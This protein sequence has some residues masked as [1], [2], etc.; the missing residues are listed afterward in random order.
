MTILEI[1]S[2]WAAIPID[3]RD[4]RR[5][6]LPSIP[7]DLEPY[8]DFLDEIEAFDVTKP[9]PIDYPKAFEL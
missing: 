9:R 6:S 3:V 4:P 5:P 2:N 8:L 1:K 7:V